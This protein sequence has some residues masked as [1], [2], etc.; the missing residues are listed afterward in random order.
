M[1]AMTIFNNVHP[2]DFA[3]IQ[4]ESGVIKQAFEDKQRFISAKKQEMQAEIDD[5]KTTVERYKADSMKS[6]REIKFAMFGDWAIGN[7]RVFES[8]VG[9]NFRK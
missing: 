5:Y 2:S 3:D 4:S 6:V 8:W 9:C 1:L 7:T